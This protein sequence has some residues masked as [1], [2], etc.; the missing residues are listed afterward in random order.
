MRRRLSGVILVMIIII[1]IYMLRRIPLPSEGNCPIPL[2]TS[3]HYLY[4]T[5]LTLFNIRPFTYIINNGI[6]DN[7]RVFLII[8][9]TSH[10]GDSEL[11]DVMRSQLP[12]SYLNT[13]HV[14][15]VSKEK[16]SD[17]QKKLHSLIKGLYYKKK[18]K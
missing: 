12:Q 13:I 1:Y 17:I 9:I 11:R 8:I 3:Q 2:P 14:K 10:P 4:P 5:N 7:A 6:C 16:R 18:D 15:R